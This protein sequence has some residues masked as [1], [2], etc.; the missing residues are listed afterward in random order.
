MKL[1]KDAKARL[2]RMTRKEKDAIIRAA[3]LLADADL[4]THMRWTAI[5]RNARKTYDMR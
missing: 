4:I 2:K 1:S 3:T 5:H